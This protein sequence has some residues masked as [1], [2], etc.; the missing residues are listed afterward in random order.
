MSSKHENISE[1]IREQRKKFR[2]MSPKKKFEYFWEYYK[3]PTFAI[4]GVIILVASLARSMIE[5]SKDTVLYAAF[6]NASPAPDYEAMQRSFADRLGVSLDEVFVTI[7]SSFQL[8]SELTS[9]S[10]LAG[11]QKL[12]AM[13]AANQLDILAADVE[14][15]KYLAG[16]GYYTDLRTILPEDLLQKYEPY[17]VYYTFDPATKKAQMEESGIPYEEDDL[18]PFETLEPVPYGISSEAFS[19]ILYDIYYGMPSVV[20]ICVSGTNIEN[21]VQFLTFLEEYQP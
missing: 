12:M 9:T 8:S 17:L 18:G 7:D 21:A 16:N 11:T 5:N 13:S 1:E 20:G 2:E 6:I 3:I 19:D 4:I 10:D 15:A 14:T